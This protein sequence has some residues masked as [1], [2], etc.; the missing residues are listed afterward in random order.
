M[1]NYQKINHF[2]DMHLITRKNTLA[3]SLKKIARL[4]PKEFQFFPDTWVMPHEWYELEAHVAELK[5]GTEEFYIVKPERGCQGRGIYIVNRI[6]DIP[7]DTNIVVQKYIDKPFLIEG[8]KFDLRIYVMVTW[9]NPLRVFLYKEG[10]AWF[11]T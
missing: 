3:A 7:L 5:P 8:F 2:P 1:K 10:M 11:A 4:I 9:V 6:T